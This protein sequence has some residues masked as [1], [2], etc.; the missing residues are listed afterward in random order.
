MGFAWKR[1]PSLQS[2]SPLPRTCAL[3]VSLVAPHLA[4]CTSIPANK[5]PTSRHVTPIHPKPP[6]PHHL[7]RVSLFALSVLREGMSRSASPC[8]HCPSSGFSRWAYKPFRKARSLQRRTGLPRV[9]LD[10]GCNPSPL[11]HSVS[12]VYVP[13]CTTRSCAAYSRAG[14]TLTAQNCRVHARGVL[15]SSRVRGSTCTCALPEA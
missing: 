14:L 1:G 7:P 6:P 3:L 13:H 11:L 15:R 9:V 5:L 2:S 12:A 10:R 8:I 4:L